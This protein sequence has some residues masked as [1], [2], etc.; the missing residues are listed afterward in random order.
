VQDHLPFRKA[1]RISKSKRE[2]DDGEE[3]PSIGEGL[4]K[5]WFGSRNL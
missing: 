4:A 5:K 2:A 1:I 3:G